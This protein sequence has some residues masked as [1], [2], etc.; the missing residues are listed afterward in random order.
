MSKLVR[1]PLPS[2]VTLWS[3]ISTTLVYIDAAY[4][5]GLKFGFIQLVPAIIRE[6]WQWY[7]ESDTQYSGDGSGMDPGN[8]WVETQSMFN[9]FESVGTL[10]FLFV[11]KKNTLASTLTILIV[12]VA[13]FW[14]TALYMSII[15]NSSDPVMVVPLLHCAGF[16]A[17]RENT[18]HVAGVLAKEG[19]GTQ[20]F[21]VQF[22]FWWLVMPLLVISAAWR[23]VDRAI[24]KQAKAA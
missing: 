23:S 22:N 20:F 7:G 6:G 12:N 16:Q 17:R 1:V 19:C 24:T 4:V 2:W 13:V 10:L 18:A 11:L 21:K 9:L 3:V 5:L 15:L 14:K 8:G